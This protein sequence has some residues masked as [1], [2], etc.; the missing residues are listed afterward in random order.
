[1]YTIVYRDKNLFIT[2]GHRIYQNDNRV[3]KIKFFIDANYED[4][5]M[6]D[7]D[8]II[9]IVLPD[10]VSGKLCYLNFESELYKE[11]YIVSYLPITKTITAQKGNIE[12]R[13]SFFKHDIATDTYYTM[14]TNMIQMIIYE[15]NIINDVLIPVDETD[16][17]AQI[18][19]QIDQLESTK[20][21]Y[22]DYDDTT[23]LL[24]LYGDLE[25]TN[26]L[27]S[28]ILN[29]DVVWSLMDEGGV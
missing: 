16:I 8:A 14:N 2:I 6:R 5:N 11:K 20:A 25:K 23:K 1:M 12:L 9:Q 24:T 15:S 4:L 22:I 27:T 18:Q 3:D 17:L 10:G 26:I 13:I 19:S 7:F 21:G 29:D 28:V